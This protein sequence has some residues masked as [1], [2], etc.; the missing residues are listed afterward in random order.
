M[1]MVRHYDVSEQ[2][3]TAGSPASSIAP[4]VIDLMASVRKIGK[5]SLPTAVMNKQ[6]SSFEMG[7][8]TL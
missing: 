1:K 8:L 6:G 4:Q 3:K 7:S 2:K 5:R